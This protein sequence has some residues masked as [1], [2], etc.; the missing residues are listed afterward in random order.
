MKTNP[1]IG[2]LFMVWSLASFAQSQPAAQTKFP[3]AGTYKNTKL[4]YKIIS[5]PNATYAYDIYSDS[6]LIIHQPSIP[7]VAGNE[8]FKT[9]AGAQK[10]A[11][12]VITKI[13]KG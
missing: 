4:S 12:L 10:V 9:K 11:Q 13:D 5:A 3:E 2:L 7:G 6:K 1:F 8:G